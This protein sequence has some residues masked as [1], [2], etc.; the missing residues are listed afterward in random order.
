MPLKKY[1]AMPSGRMAALFAVAEYEDMAVLDF[2]TRGHGLFNYGHMPWLIPSLQKNGLYTTHISETEAVLGDSSRLTEAAREAVANGYKAALLVP[3]AMGGVLGYDFYE[4]AQRASNESGADIFTFPLG[5]H[6]DF[7]KGG[8]AVTLALA[9]KFCREKANKQEG[10]FAVLGGGY[11]QN[12]RRVNAETAELISRCLGCEC[13]FDNLNCKS[14]FKW[15]DCARAEFVAVTSQNALRAAECIRDRLGVPFVFFRTL[16][17][18]SED[19]A[20][21][22]A[23]K[24]AN[25][26]YAPKADEVYD[27]A[28]TCFIN[29]L[30]AEKPEIVCYS[31]IDR[32][33]AVKRFFA[34]MGFG[35]RCLCSHAQSEEDCMEINAFTDLYAKKEDALV[36]SYD[37]VCRRMARGVEIEYTGGRYRL[38]TPVCPPQSGKNG[39]YELMRKITDVL[40]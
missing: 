37:T 17:K 9:Q 32:L 33:R 35:V 14:A 13:L 23:A 36:L 40:L 5:L 2:S 16:G 39:A 26:K 28:R 27:Y 15:C 18:E 6:D 3:S 24:T 1:A 22:T 21:A 20:L 19:E 10:T 30:R 25:V 31:D 34:A 38:L 11:T 8:E 4:L 12:D 29:V 7:Y